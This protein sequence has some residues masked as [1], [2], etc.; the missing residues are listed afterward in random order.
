M[1]N[2]GSGRTNIIY[3]G[4]QRHDGY[5][6]VDGD[7]F[8]L[9]GDRH[10]QAKEGVELARN[11]TGIGREATEERFDTAADMHTARFVGKIPSRRQIGAALNIFGDTPADFVANFQRWERNHF[12][13]EPGRLWFLTPGAEDRYLLARASSEA[14]LGGVEVDPT[15]TSSLKN[16]EWGWNSDSPYFFGRLSSTPLARQGSTRTYQ[17]AVK[18]PSTADVVYPQIFLRGLGS[19]KVRFRAL[20]GDPSTEISFNVP[21]LADNE[22]ARIDFSPANPTFLK[23]NVSSGKVTNLW[24]TMLGKRP[25]AHLSPETTFLVVAERDPAAAG[26]PAALPRVEFTPL[27]SSWI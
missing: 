2:P 5:Q 20:A 24:P 18:N 21:H 10:L 4:P 27:F 26:S 11:L 19:W 3:E 6:W 16:Y 14:G 22:E 23:R 12:Q 15:L 7:K 9:S 13:S 1:T 17:A 8:H 25:K